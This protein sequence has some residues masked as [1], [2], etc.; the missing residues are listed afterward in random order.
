MWDRCRDDGSSLFHPTSRIAAGSI[1]IFGIRHDG[2][3]VAVGYRDL[4]LLEVW[5]RLKGVIRSCAQERARAHDHNWRD[6]IGCH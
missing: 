5:L 3:R 1:G 2:S 4:L 6:L